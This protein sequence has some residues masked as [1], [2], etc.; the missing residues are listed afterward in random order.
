MRANYAAPECEAASADLREIL[1]DS[2]T[3]SGF[4]DY[5]DETI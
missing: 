5:T 2:F 4:D 3:G 1:C